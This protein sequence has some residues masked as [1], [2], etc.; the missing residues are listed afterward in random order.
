M[1][2][3]DRAPGGLAR[4]IAI[5]TG[6]DTAGLLVAAVVVRSLILYL[7]GVAALIV[8]VATTFA[9]IYQSTAR[10]NE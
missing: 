1:A 10:A 2:S 5:I 4:L 8:C 6:L 7:I 3:T 9:W